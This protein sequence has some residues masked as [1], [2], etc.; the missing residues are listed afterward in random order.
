MFLIQNS[1]NEILIYILNPIFLWS[2]I[3]NLPWF[4]SL[5]FW[6][7]C[8]FAAVCQSCR[9]NLCNLCSFQTR[10]S[11]KLDI[12]FFCADCNIV[13]RRSLLLIF[14]VHRFTALCSLSYVNCPWCLW[15]MDLFLY[16]RCKNQIAQGL[17]SIK[18][19]KQTDVLKLYNVDP[20]KRF[21]LDFPGA[22]HFRMEETYQ[23]SCEDSYWPWMCRSQRWNLLQTLRRVPE[24]ENHQKKIRTG[25]HKKQT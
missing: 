16:I 20:E 10:L 21:L 5:Y 13:N 1:F 8:H 15:A 6:E 9:F 12:V 23:I 25:I 24:K 22:G 18:Q 7:V 2:S 4:K 17:L 11:K 3:F 19:A 14:C